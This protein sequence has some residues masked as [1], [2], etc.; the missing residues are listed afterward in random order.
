MSVLD[1]TRHDLGVESRLKRDALLLELGAK[2]VGVQQVAV[3]RDGAGPEGRMVKRQ[4]VRVFSPAGA[5]R[6]VPRVTERD[7]RTFAEVFDLRR[8]E[9]LRHKPHVAVDA[10]RRSVGDRDAG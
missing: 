2:R 9:D 6:R 10:H 3:V 1:E 5:G 4:R 8:R 7:D